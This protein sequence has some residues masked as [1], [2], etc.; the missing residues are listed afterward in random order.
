MRKLLYL[1][2]GVVVLPLLALSTSTA[3]VGYSLAYWMHK[4]GA[5]SAGSEPEAR[6]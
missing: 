4:Y 6:G 1:G 3:P 5:K 2:L